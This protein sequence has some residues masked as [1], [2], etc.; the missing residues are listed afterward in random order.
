MARSW[1]IINQPERAQAPDM[2]ETPR[3]TTYSLLFTRLDATVRLLL[4]VAALLR[5]L[6]ELGLQ[7]W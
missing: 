2:T 3:T 4:R 1:L 6:D 7:L 5:L